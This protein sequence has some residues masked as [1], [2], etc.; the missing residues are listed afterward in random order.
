MCGVIDQRTKKPSIGSPK[1]GGAAHSRLAMPATSLLLTC[2]P[3]QVDGVVGLV[4]IG[5]LLLL[6]SDVPIALVART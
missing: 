3:A 2:K 1:L 6:Q 5:S 4:V